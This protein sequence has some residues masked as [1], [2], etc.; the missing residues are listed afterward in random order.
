MTCDR[1][2]ENRGTAACLICHCDLCDE[3]SLPWSLAG[4]P[5]IKGVACVVGDAWCKPEGEE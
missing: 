4:K 5:W 1:C 2:H 3:C